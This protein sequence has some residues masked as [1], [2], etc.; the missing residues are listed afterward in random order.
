MEC[1]CLV[2][3]D[4]GVDLHQEVTSSCTTYGPWEKETP[5]VMFD[6]LRYNTVRNDV[7]QT[8][9]R[10]IACQQIASDEISGSRKVILKHEIESR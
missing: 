2:P 5:E 1:K 7:I 10:V 6:V 3:L 9:N 4:R 8:E